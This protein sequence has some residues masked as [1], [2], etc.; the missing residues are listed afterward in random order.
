M[1]DWVMNQAMNMD[2]LLASYEKSP[3]LVREKASA[4]LGFPSLASGRPNA[5]MGL[6]A[7][8]LAELDSFIVS[9]ASAARTKTH[10]I[11]QNKECMRRR[12]MYSWH[13]L[14]DD[15]YSKGLP[16][17]EDYQ[18][19]TKEWYGVE[20]SLWDKDGG[21]S[22]E[23]EY[24]RWCNDLKDMSE[25]E[26]AALSSSEEWSSARSRARYPH[27]FKAAL[28]HSS[29]AVSNVPVERVFAYMRKMEAFDR[30][31]MDEDSFDY[32]LFFKCNHWI[33][34]E[35]FEEDLARMPSMKT[36]IDLFQHEVA[37]FFKK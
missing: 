24:K 34:C 23:I 1:P 35:L 18:K 21:A 8:E 2:M 27:I 36:G 28:W 37:S 5:A 4:L 25:E 26:R 6:S 3:L 31:T 19:R 17:A 32:E 33:V 22:V 9:A 20:A 7:A 14:H 11:E 29:V 15:D 30:L 16:T 13:S 10:H 12:L